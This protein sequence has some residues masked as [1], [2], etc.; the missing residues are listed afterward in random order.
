MNYLK[1]VGIGLLSFAGVVLLFGIPTALIPT[2]W[3]ARM[4]PAR[5][6]D[7]VFLFLNSGLIGTYIGLHSYEKHERS[8]KGD[9]LAT[10]GSIA[11]IFAVGCPI[12]NKVLV[13]L[14][15][16]SAVMAYFEP[17]R[18]WLGLFS[19]GVI[20]S[21]LWFKIKNVKSCVECKKGVVSA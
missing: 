11:N 14:L 6:S 5:T 16:A 9:A 17:M 4:I 13:A 19:A 10:T 2:Q 12:C 3:F 8:K 7:Y 18:I 20:G 15:G 21:A 1:Y